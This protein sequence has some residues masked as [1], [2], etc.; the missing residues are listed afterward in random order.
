MFFEEQRANLF[1]TSKFAVIT[2]ENG[3]IRG[4]FANSTLKRP[5]SSNSGEQNK[6]SAKTKSTP[7]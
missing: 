3:R 7:C 4:F 2:N 1:K 6:N 5:L